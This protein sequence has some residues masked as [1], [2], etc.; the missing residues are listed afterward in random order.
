[1]INSISNQLKL[2]SAGFTLL[3]VVIAMGILA[4]GLLGL[5]SL[6]ATSQKLSYDS[7]IRAQATNLAYSIIDA[8]RVNRTEAFPPNYSYNY[9]P[10]FIGTAPTCTTNANGVTLTQTDIA[11]QDLAVWAELLACS[12]PQGNASVVVTNPVYSGANVISA[13]ATVTVQ[14]STSRQQT[15]AE[16]AANTA[17]GTTPLGTVTVVSSL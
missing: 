17:S 10:N 5:A 14:W 4:V 13:T 16:T 7:S 9:N 1:M 8:M 11:A 12:L 3:E 6:Q 15:A 2:K